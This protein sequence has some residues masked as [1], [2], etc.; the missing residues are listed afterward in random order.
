MWV[1]GDLKDRLGLERRG[2]GG[3]QSERL[4][5]F[6]RHRL[7]NLSEVELPTRNVYD[8]PVEDSPSDVGT[9]DPWGGREKTENPPQPQ[10]SHSRPEGSRPSPSPSPDPDRRYSYYSSS[11]IPSARVTPTNSTLLSGPSAPRPAHLDVQTH[12][13]RPRAGHAAEASSDSRASDRS[14]RTAQEASS[15]NDPLD[16]DRP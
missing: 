7:E 16:Q 4:S 12:D 14:Y 9:P 3:S 1:L 2:K 10:T 13:L 11:Q 5:L 15:D 6:R 8:R